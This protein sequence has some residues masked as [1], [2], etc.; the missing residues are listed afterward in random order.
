M[1][2]LSQLGIS[3]SIEKPTPN[4]VKILISEMKDICTQ[5]EKLVVFTDGACSHN[6]TKH[7]KAG[8][9]VVW[10]YNRDLDSSKRLIGMDQ[11]N[12]RAEYSALIEAQQIAD[13]IDPS[14][15]KPL[16]VYTDSQLL[17]NSITKWLPDW[18]KNNWKKSDKKPVLNQDLLKKI[19]TN[20]RP[21]VFKHVRAH[22]GRNDWESTYNNEADKLARESIMR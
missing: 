1:N 17:I 5:E 22:T 8:Y 20:D 18:K 7:A 12:N 3:T 2:V 16:Y 6:G 10:P 15:Q 14:G 4:L 11:T 13:T 21:I 9:A 19:D